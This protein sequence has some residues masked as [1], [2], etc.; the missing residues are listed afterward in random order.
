MMHS[1]SN[2]SNSN[3]NNSNSLANASVSQLL[4]KSQ[5]LSD[6]LLQ[7]DACVPALEMWDSDEEA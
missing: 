5:M 2:N 7:D 6:S 3:S 1:Q 4:T